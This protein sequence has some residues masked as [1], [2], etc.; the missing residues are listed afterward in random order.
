MLNDILKH[1]TELINCQSITPLSDG[2]IEYIE[3][4][5]TQHGFSVIT[6][7]F[8]E[9]DYQVTNLYAV[10]GASKPNI[11]FAGHVD[12]VPAG[13]RDSWSHNP[14]KATKV[15]DKIYG[16]GVVDM[17][18][19]LACSLAATI[20]FIKLKPKLNG[21]VSFLLTSDEEG[22]AK[23]GT[24]KMLPYLTSLNHKID[25]A[26]LGEPTCE[27]EVGDIMKIGRRGSVNFTLT[28]HGIQGHVAYPE[29]A[30]NPIHCLVKIMHNLSS[31]QLDYGS[32][33]FMASNLEITSIDV[34]NNTTNIIP[35]TASAKFNIRFNDLHGA[36][37]IVTLIKRI[38]EQHTLK[39]ELIPSVSANVFIQ[40]PNHLIS[41]FAKI[42]PQITGII[43]KFSTSGGT[44]DARFI[45]NYCQVVE[46]GL[47][48]ETAHKIDEYTT[49]SDLQRL[50]SVY[51]G[52]LEKFVG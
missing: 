15:E 10:Y 14:Y 38:V 47:L 25:L 31:L 23:Y 29:L 9:H 5:L 33:Q 32:K 48:S 20:E 44:S 50:Y 37:S 49:I 13:D 26:I 8:G 6:K 45:K 42:I 28:I 12:V 30:E 46:F 35:G 16:R 36:E 11:C 4:L 52:A 17:K 51:Y 40:E 1:L 2:S 24:S 39:Y 21:S 34:G 43:P 7:T 19:A 22:A 41:E 18:G 27:H 3:K